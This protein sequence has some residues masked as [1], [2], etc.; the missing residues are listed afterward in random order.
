MRI[1]TAGL[2]GLLFALGLALGGMTDANNVIGFLDVTGEWK[3][4]LAFVMAGALAVFSVGRRL[5]LR[6]G[7]PLYAD[8][9][10]RTRVGVD[11]PLV[12]G[13]A[14]FGL[15]WGIAG[16]CPGPA[17]VSA[18]SS[19]DALLFVGAML[20]GLWLAGRRADAVVPAV[21]ENAAPK[22]G[23]VGLDGCS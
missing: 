22:A 6:R 20:G 10:P 9:F 11:R 19:A 12:V 16:Y 17:L 5:A 1:L 14:L 7:R 18:A 21:V 4:G 3:P 15:G 23:D 8:R 2:S 13:S